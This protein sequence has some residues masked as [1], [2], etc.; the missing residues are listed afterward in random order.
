MIYLSYIG[1]EKVDDAIFFFLPKDTNTKNESKP[2]KCMLYEANK[3]RGKFF[4][5]VR[6]DR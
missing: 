2:H 5:Y 4:M 6:L 1:C 3:N